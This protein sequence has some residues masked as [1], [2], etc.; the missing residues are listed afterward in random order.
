GEGQSALGGPACL[1][2][3]LP[4]S[5]HALP[6]EIVPRLGHYNP[7]AR[8]GAVAELDNDPVTRQPESI[9]QRDRREGSAKGPLAASCLQDGDLAGKVR[10]AALRHRS[11]LLVHRQ[12]VIDRWLTRRGLHL[13]VAQPAELDRF[14]QPA[15]SLGPDADLSQPAVA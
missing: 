15:Q 5:D 6:A 7:L 1:T 11:I 12:Q 2:L 8:V 10:P 14:E 13:L 4:A 3:A 9:G